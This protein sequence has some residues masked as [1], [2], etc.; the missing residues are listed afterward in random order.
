MLNLGTRWRW[1]RLHAHDTI[2]PGE[3]VPPPYTLD[4]RLSVPQ[5]QSGHSGKEKKIPSLALL[6][7]KP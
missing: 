5:S 7:I 6:G 2:T 1:C 4:R 3:R